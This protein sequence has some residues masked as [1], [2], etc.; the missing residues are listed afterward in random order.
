MH[1][2]EEAFQRVDKLT[3]EIL[4]IA[5]RIDEETQAVSKHVSD[6]NRS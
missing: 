3:Q 1:G 6:L 2:L 4:T 5:A